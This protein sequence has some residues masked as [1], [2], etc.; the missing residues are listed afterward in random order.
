MFRRLT[1]FV[2]IIGL[3]VLAFGCAAL[4]DPTAASATISS[5][6]V[7]GLVPTVGGTSSS[8]RRQ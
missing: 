8:Q 1:P 2:V 7:T 5:I 3:G 4:T 6:N